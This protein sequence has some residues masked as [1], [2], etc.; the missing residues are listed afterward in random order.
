MV[1]Q[2]CLFRFLVYLQAV[3]N[4]IRLLN[5]SRIMLTPKA[6]KPAK[7]FFP[8]WYVIKFIVV[9]ISKLLRVCVSLT[10]VVLVSE[11]PFL[12]TFFPAV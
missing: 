5:I 8:I 12:V 3:P 9:C 2:C 10:G 7:I 4:Y 6:S 1:E 11:F